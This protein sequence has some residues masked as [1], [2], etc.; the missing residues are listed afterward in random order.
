MTTLAQFRTK[1]QN[2]LGLTTLPT[3]E[4]DRAVERAVHDLSQVLPKQ[5]TL[6]VFTS[7]NISKEYTIGAVDTDLGYKF[8]DP[9][10]DVVPDAKRNVDYTIDYIQGILT[11]VA[12]STDLPQARQLLS[13]SRLLR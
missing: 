12:S 5:K 10:S 9:V 13:H 6:S 4:A 7:W 8:I 3:T 2:D 1:L 11:R